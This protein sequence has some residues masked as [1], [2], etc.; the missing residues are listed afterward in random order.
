MKTLIVIIALA[1]NVSCA[2]TQTAIKAAKDSAIQCGTAAAKARTSEF[3]PML[4]KAILDHLDSSTRKVDWEPVKDLTKGFLADSG[5]CVFANVVA[6]LRTQTTA[7]GAP[8]TAAVDVDPSSLLEGFR[9]IADG[10]AYVA[11][12]G[13]TV[14]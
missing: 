9:S 7:T 1:L 6:A 12:D 8:M 2:G 11:A 3:G 13:S 14:Q 5:M 4:E 10:Q